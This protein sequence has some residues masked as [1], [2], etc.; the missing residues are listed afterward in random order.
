MFVNMIFLSPM[1]R[2][3]FRACE[4]HSV[5]QEHISFRNLMFLLQDAYYYRNIELKIKIYQNYFP[6]K[7]GFLKNE[8]MTSSCLFQVETFNK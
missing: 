1:F 8:M 2:A 5:K 6:L 3:C 7:Y 4:F